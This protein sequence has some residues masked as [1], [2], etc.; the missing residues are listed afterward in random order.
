MIDW[1]AF[2]IVAGASLVSAIVVVGLYSLGLRLLTTGGR[3]PLVDPAEFTGA[4]TVLT[5]KRAAKIAKRTRKA[6]AANPLTD[7]Q[8]R[9]AIAAGYA[10]FVLCAGAGLYG[11]YLVIPALHR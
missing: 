2:V 9:I 5:P 10:C 7:S 6:A 4:I 8:K 11:V 1:L 3:I